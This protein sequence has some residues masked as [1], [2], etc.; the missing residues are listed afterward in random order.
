MRPPT[1][2][3]DRLLGQESLLSGD[4]RS[5]INV[6]MSL[7]VTCSEDADLIQDRPQDKDTLLGDRFIRQLKAQCA[8]WPH[9]TRPA[10]FHQPFTGSIP[11]LVLSGQLDPITPPEWGKQ[12]VA[13]LSNARQLVLKGQGHGEF[14]VGCTPR[15]VRQ[16][17]DKP[18]PKTLDASC[19]KRLG[20]TP[21]YLNF[22]GAKP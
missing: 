16:F 7:S 8:I 19:L 18:D 13:H 2:I 11:T 9:G 14:Q 5:D 6:G 10:D 15:I 1:A 22:N 4:L 3:R 12:I 20:P 21:M 17:I